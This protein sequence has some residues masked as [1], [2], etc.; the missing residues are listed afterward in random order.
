MVVIIEN[1]IASKSFIQLA[2][3]Y[4]LRRIPKLEFTKTKTPPRTPQMA[5]TITEPGSTS[6]V[7]GEISFVP[8]FST[9]EFKFERG[10][11]F[12][13]VWHRASVKTERAHDRNTFQM[14]ENLQKVLGLEISKAKSVPPTG[15][16]NA[17]LT[18][19][20]VPAAIKWRLWVSF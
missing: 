2:L 3:M 8:N 17:A 16:P 6:S 19:A 5:P 7:G 13:S 20:E 12:I 18:P 9:D 10:L 1:K 11:P 14:T 4:F 15:A